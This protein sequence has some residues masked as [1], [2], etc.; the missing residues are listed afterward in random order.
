MDRILA[1]RQILSSGPGAVLVKGGHLL[2][3][4]GCDLLVTPDGCQRF[5]GEWIETRNTHGTGCTYSAA[6]ATQLARGLPL[7]E[8]IGVARAYL[9]EAI[10]HGPNRQVVRVSELGR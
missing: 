2:E 9:T 4:R 1:G 10:R 7:A 3:D 5:S 6:I 8:A